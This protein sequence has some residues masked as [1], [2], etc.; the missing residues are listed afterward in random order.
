MSVQFGFKIKVECDSCDEE[1]ESE[2]RELWETF[3][4]RARDAGWKSR[5]VRADEWTHGCPKHEA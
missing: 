2:P 4:P 5:R 3:W 1:I